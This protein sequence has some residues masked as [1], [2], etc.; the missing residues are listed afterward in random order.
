MLEKMTENHMNKILTIQMGGSLCSCV[1]DRDRKRF[2]IGSKYLMSKI[3][4]K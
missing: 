2:E 4:Q 1:R 3:D